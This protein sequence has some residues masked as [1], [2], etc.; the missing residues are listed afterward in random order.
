V[1]DRV[2]LPFKLKPTPGAPTVQAFEGVLPTKPE[3]PA[4][5]RDNRPDHPYVPFGP[6]EQTPNPAR[7]HK[8]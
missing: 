3:L 1:G 8:P 5:R 6:A 4:Q 7:V 2:S